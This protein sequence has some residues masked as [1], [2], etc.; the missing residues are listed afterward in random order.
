[1]SNILKAE[2]KIVFMNLVDIRINSTL[3]KLRIE[4]YS[5]LNILPTEC[6]HMIQSNH[7]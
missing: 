6:R 1:M 2:S 7:R 5:G 4:V 3:L